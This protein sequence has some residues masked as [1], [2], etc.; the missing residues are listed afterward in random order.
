MWRIENQ[1]LEGINHAHKGSYIRISLFSFDRMPLTDA[2]IRA[3]KRGVRVQV[4]LNNHQ[5]NRA[6]RKLKGAL[7]TNRSRPSFY[8]ICVGSCRAGYENLHTKMVLFGYT[9]AVKNVIMTGS[10]NF[11]GNAAVNQH[12]DLYTTWNKPNMYRDFLGLYRQLKADR[13]LSAARQHYIKRA[14]IW[15]LEVLPLPGWNVKNDPQM[16]EMRKITC[17]GANGGTGINGRTVIRVGMHTISGKRG[18]WLAKKVRQ[19]FAQGCNVR[20]WYSWADRGARNVFATR[21]ARGYVPV[22]VAGYDTDYDG[23]IDLYGHHKV[24]LVS[25]NYAGDRSS[26][27]IW[28]GSSNWGNAGLRGDEIILRLK[29]VS[30]FRDWNRNFDSIWY[31][32]SYLAKYIPYRTSTRLRTSS[33]WDAAKPEPELT[34]PDDWEY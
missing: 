21:T 13:K 24:L 23:E 17:T 30:L 5:I 3:K 7:G 12:N 22:H 1:I 8:H 11:T 29:G 6:M 14:G 28:T 27:H 31:S 32:H 16:R 33:A 10:F 25:G 9:G 2:L 34:P 18:T 4:I 26:A 19:L 15:Q 20:V